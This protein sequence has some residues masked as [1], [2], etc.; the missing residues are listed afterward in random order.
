MTRLERDNLRSRGLVEQEGLH[1]SYEGAHERAITNDCSIRK[2]RCFAPLRMTSP[3]TGRRRW[4]ELSA[5][6]QPVAKRVAGPLQAISQAGVRP[7]EAPIGDEHLPGDGDE[8]RTRA[9]D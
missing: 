7:G 8:L 9:I 2:T 3:H 5:I 6:A 4:R 1:Q